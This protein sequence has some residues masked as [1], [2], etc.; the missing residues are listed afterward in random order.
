[1]ALPPKRPE[2]GARDATMQK[3]RVLDK[4]CS[5]LAKPTMLLTILRDGRA[6]EHNEPIL[7]L[8]SWNLA[9]REFGFEFRGLVILTVYV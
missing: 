1:M 8:P 2:L 5:R 6:L 9:M 3:D 7:T 4:S